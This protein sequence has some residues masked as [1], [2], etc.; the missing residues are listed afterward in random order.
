V[1]LNLYKEGKRV[2]TCSASDD[3]YEV[4]TSGYYSDGEVGDIL[5]LV[6]KHLVIDE[7]RDSRSTETLDA[8]IIE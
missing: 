3:S 4:S 6:G 5:K 1:S 7:D 8:Y 2:K